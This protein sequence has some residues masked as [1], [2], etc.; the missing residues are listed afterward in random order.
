[1][2]N[3]N[4]SIHPNYYEKTVDKYLSRKLQPPIELTTTKFFERKNLS[5]F[6]RTH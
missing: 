2:C 3:Y 1:M 4:N 6:Q 5:S